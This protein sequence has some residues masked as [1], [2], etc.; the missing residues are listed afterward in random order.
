MVEV[1]GQTLY[2]LS[3]IHYP[4]SIIHYPLSTIHCPLSI[5]SPLDDLM[6]KGKI[7]WQNREEKKNR[8]I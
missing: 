1:G 7:T 5:V 6:K 4:L 2:E 3:I 8:Y